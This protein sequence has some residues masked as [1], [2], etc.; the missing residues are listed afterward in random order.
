[1]ANTPSA[2]RRIKVSERNRKRN[3]SAISAIRTAIKNVRLAKQKNED[4]K[5]VLNKA[6]S[7]IDK[8]ILKGIL[9]KNTGSRYKSRISA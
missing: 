2:K 9:H 6:Y 8:A 4:A 3:Q 5:D 1:M 7:L